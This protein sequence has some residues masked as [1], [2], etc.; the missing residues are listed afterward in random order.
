MSVPQSEKFVRYCILLTHTGKP[1]TESLVRAHVA[2]LKKLDG[3]GKLELCGPFKDYKGGM[4]LIRA[5]DYQDATAIAASDPFV[6]EGVETFEIRT[7]E[8]SCEENNHLGM[9]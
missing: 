4:I 9:G 6:T 3:E 7:L 5:R 8:L 1:F 2:H